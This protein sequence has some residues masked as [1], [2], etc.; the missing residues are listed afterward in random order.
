MA[1][2]D[3]KKRWAYEWTMKAT[4]CQEMTKKTSEQ[5]LTLAEVA[6][7]LSLSKRAIYRLIAKGSLAK[8]VKIGGA[9]R[10]CES[11]LEQFLETLK[12]ERK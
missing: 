3:E 1:A 5:L 2:S 6:L 4:A 8:P 10:I 11:D 9:T 12:A 7:R